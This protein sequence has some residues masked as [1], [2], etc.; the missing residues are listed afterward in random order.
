MNLYFIFLKIN[1]ILTDASFIMDKDMSIKDVFNWLYSHGFPE[2]RA[3]KFKG[4]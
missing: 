2:T 1:S 4:N 3:Q